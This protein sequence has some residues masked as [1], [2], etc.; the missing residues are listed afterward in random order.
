MIRFIHA[1]D[2]HIDSPFEGLEAYDGAPV[3]TLPGATRRAFESL[4]DLAID[5]AVD[6]LLIAGDVYGGDW[7][8]VSTGLF[9]VRQMNRLHSA[10]IPAYLISGNHDAAS[11]LTRRLSLPG[12]VHLFSSRKAESKV[13]PGLPVVVHGRSFP[14]RAVPENLVPDYPA[15]ESGMFNIGLLHTS[16]A[17]APGHDTYAPCSLRDLTDKG[18][19]YWA[20]GHVHK[21]QVLCRDP[22]VVFAG[23]TQGR[24][25]RETG[26]RGCRLVTVNDSREVV[27]AEHRV[28]D[29]VRWAKVAVDLAAV[30]SER[31]ALKRIGAGLQQAFAQAEGRLLAVRVTLTGATALHGRLKRNL[32]WLRAECIA[33]GQMTAGDR[34]W[35]EEVEVRTSALQDLAQLA[36]RDDLTRVVLETL[37]AAGARRLETDAETADMLQALPSEIR[38]EVEEELADTGRA[39]LLDDVRS[40]LLDALQKGGE[41]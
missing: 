33:W 1:A 38:A 11:V 12:N 34:V 31:E 16:L 2:T 5:E 15:P 17:G 6:F 29:L 32:P 30:E 20:L 39:I 26:P 23:N 3:D 24:H 22:W 37:R 35:I 19:D 4:V 9:F 8:D 36:A 25:I 40:I 13:V 18:Y 10:G 41:T 28:M 14:Q 27:D 21:P 7:K